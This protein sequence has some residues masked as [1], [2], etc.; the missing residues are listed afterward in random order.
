MAVLGR[1]DDP[2]LAKRFAGALAA[3]MAAVGISLDYAPVLDV[4]TNPKNPVIGDR[5]LGERPEIVAP[6]GGARQE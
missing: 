4:H 3:E 2:A 6:H 5:A 1:S